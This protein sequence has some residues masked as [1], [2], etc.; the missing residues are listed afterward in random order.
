IVGPGAPHYVPHVRSS[1]GEHAY[2]GWDGTA[3]IDG[4]ATPQDGVCWYRCEV[5]Q[6]RALSLAVVD[7][8]NI[9]FMVHAFRGVISQSLSA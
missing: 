2:Q 6:L 1:V 5:S 7:N 4:P 8:V 3:W 9:G